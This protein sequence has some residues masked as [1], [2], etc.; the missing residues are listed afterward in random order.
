MLDVA[1]RALEDALG[2]GGY[3]L[4]ADKRQAIESECQVSTQELLRLAVHVARPRARVPVSGYCVGSAGLTEDGEI[5]LGV[6]LEYASGPLAQTIHSEQFLLS[7]S[8]ASSASPLTMLAVSAPPCG[9]CR[10]F[11]READPD[12][13]M[14]LLIADDPAV[15]IAELLP[16]AFTPRDLGVTDPFYANPLAVYPEHDIATVARLA[17]DVA[18]TPYSGSLAGAAVRTIHGQVHGGS[19]LENAAY[20]PTLPPLQAALIAFHA[21]GSTRVEELDEVVICQK[22]GLVD[23][24][25]QARILA[26]ALGVKPE[27][28][29]FLER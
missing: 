21:E 7:Y 8:R 20:N 9:H 15:A 3:R 2:V 11:L 18:Y 10:Q 23:Y 6:N 12:G 16:R 5:F 28:F 27:R 1:A 25:P 29:R 14:C 22:D 26:L 19:A 4:S 13:K 24:V 17:S